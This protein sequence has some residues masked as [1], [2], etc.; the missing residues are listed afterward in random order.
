MIKKRN[1]DP[2][3][4]NWIMAQTG[5]GPGIGEVHYLCGE[6]TSYYSWLRDDMKI[7]PARIHHTLAKGEDALKANRNDCLI[8]MPDS[9]VQSTTALAWDKART[10]LIGAGMVGFMEHDV[11]FTNGDADAT[12]TT[13]NWVFSGDNCLIQNVCFRHRGAAANVINTSI[14]G[15]NIHCVNVHFHNMA[16]TAT[17]DEAG[18]KGTVLD[19]CNQAVFRNCVFGGTE[20]ERTDGAAD[21]TIGAGTCDNLLFEDCL[22]IA[23]LDANAD[24]DHAF[25]ETV[26][27]ADLGKFA[28]F[29]KARFVNCGAA[30]DQLPDCITTGASLAGIMVFE[31]VF[32]VGALD[33]ADNEERVWIKPEGHDTTAGKF[34][35]IAINPDVAA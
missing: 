19:G 29:K 8:V 27:D 4:V 16:N 22:W 9:Y 6:D 15:D 18:M 7:E 12:P 10:H 11:E 28:M 5:L 33:L 3:L 35:G 20:I 34:V 23:D 2:S 21:M 14:Q 32:V 25:I 31:D 26:A 17:A 1:L 30:M 13:G 24:D